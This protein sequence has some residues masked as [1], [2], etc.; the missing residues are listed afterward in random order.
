MRD[1][2]S[3]ALDSFWWSSGGHKKASHVV[4]ENRINVVGVIAE[5]TTQGQEPVPELVIVEGGGSLFDVL[6]AVK[7]KA[8]PWPRN[9]GE[10]GLRRVE[11]S[12][13]GGVRAFGQLSGDGT[14]RKAARLFEERELESILFR[15]GDDGSDLFCR[16]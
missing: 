5:D 13:H 16:T 8:Q 6:V 14:E 10:G 2:R 4:S 15:V 9:G 1:V 3:M 7:I 11:L 12:A